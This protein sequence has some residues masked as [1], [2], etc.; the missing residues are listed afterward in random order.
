MKKDYSIV[1]ELEK[2]GRMTRRRLNGH[3]VYVLEPKRTISIEEAEKRFRKI[4]AK[5][6]A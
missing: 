6:R 1:E 3:I 2:R 5:M 4:A